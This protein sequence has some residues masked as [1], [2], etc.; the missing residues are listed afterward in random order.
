MRQFTY[1]FTSLDGLSETVDALADNPAIV[2][3]R[4]VLFNVFTSSRDE[5]F[6]DTCRQTIKRRFP[7]APLIGASTSGEIVD[8]VI[9]EGTTAL[10][11]LCFEKTMVTAY[12]FDCVDGC[13]NAAGTRLRKIAESLPD[14]RAI[15][16]FANVKGIDNKGFVSELNSLPEDVLVFGGG[17]DASDDSDWTLTFD[18]D[19]TYANGAVAAIFCG[20]ELN[21]VGYS[22]LG[23][24]P[25]SL[26]MTVTKTS[27]DQRT[28][29]EVDGRPAADVYKKYLRIDN[30]AS[31]HTNVQE[32][33]I[34]L[35][36]NGRDFVR[37]PFS[38]N[39]QGAIKLGADVVEGE[40]LR[41][42]Y[43][44][45]DGLMAAAAEAAREVAD[46]R[47]EALLVFSCITRKVFLQEYAEADVRRLRGI[48]PLCGF[49]TYGEILR[50][51][52]NVET[53]NCTL[54]IV[55]LREG[56]AENE[57]DRGGIEDK[58]IDDATEFQGS[59]SVVQRLVRFVEATSADL[60]A[61]NRRLIELAT[62]DMLTDVL[63]RG[64]I[65]ARL[66][67][68]VQRVNKG[69]GKISAI[70]LD[71]DDFKSIN[72]TFGHDVGDSVLIEVTK[73]ME[74]CIRKDDPIGRWGG[75]EFVVVLDGEGIDVAQKTA[76][77]I[78]TSVAEHDFATAGHITVSVGVTRAVPGED[79]IDLYRRV[80]SALYDAK[81]HG[82][83][84][85]V[86]I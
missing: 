81:Q 4:S 26:A 10:T 69:E 45:P 6:I 61:A 56:E 84:A 60:E 47:P 85:V 43:G 41:I 49:Y 23:W 86:V 65:E 54:V 11:V 2:S 15:E 74:A 77:R 57:T 78:R 63:N 28:I 37:V 14:V 5:A 39:E 72:D 53:M 16:V 42:G 64:E 7:S 68:G 25:L 24:K 48:A 80:D 13:E 46:Y 8:G 58:A 83:N 44:D 35:E 21:A 40:Q 3:A 18:A 27:A 62:R 55:G 32:F 79:L 66:D 82:K 52:G 75:E 34:I 76:E 70:M 59:M 20:K 30:D 12:G 38:S 31:F 19:A 9:S 1:S 50:L 73:V 36:R 22:C 17:A 71:I 29:E 33:P 51:D 67:A